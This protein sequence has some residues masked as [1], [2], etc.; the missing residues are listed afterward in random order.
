LYICKTNG[1]K[2]ILEFSSIVSGLEES[3]EILTFHIR[4]AVQY[5]HWN[6]SSGVDGIFVL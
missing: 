4:E 6:E 5:D 3:N 1:E 2:S